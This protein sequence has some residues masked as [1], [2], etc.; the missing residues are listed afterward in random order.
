MFDQ[1]LLS[2]VASSKDKA[3]S[4]SLTT[5][6]WKGSVSR[7]S[8]DMIGTRKVGSNLLQSPLMDNG[9]GTHIT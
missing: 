9:T 2:H 8:M 7:K 5:E 1:I 3:A 4:P 6:A